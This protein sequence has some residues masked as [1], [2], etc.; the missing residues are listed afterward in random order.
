M[1]NSS[2]KA[3]DMTCMS[4]YLCVH[5]RDRQVINLTVSVMDRVGYG[6]C[7][8]ISFSFG[9]LAVYMC[10]TRWGGPMWGVYDGI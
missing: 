2:N 6:S 8:F 4:Y 1:I 7:V 3:F 9:V 10:P 5:A